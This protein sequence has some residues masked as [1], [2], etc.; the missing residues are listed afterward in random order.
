MQSLAEAHQTH[1]QLHH[2]VRQS[3]QTKALQIMGPDDS[4]HKLELS[5]LMAR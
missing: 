4:Q 5:Q 2:F 1:Q 3:L